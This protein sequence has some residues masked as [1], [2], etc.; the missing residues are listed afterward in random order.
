MHV[1]PVGTARRRTLPQ[2]PIQLYRYRRFFARA[3]GLPHV[4]VP[5]F[6][7]VGPADY[8]AVNLFDDLYAV[9]RRALL[10]AHLH[11]PSVLLLRLHEHLSFSRIVA[12]RFFY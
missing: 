4:A 7:E 6:R 1:V 11:K 12:A 8:A 10:R 2:V 9:R 5:R 3:N